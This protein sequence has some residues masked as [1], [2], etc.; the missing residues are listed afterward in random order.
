[1]TEQSKLYRFKQ[2]YKQR[3]E[4]PIEKP[5]LTL[6]FV[7]VTTLAPYIFSLLGLLFIIMFQRTPPPIESKILFSG[8]IFIMLAYSYISA[9]RLGKCIRVLGEERVSKYRTF[10]IETQHIKILKILK[11]IMYLGYILNITVCVL[12]IAL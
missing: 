8:F 1:M 5:K 3:E 10:Y 7:S 9:L 2:W 12:L 4:H 11:I 6:F